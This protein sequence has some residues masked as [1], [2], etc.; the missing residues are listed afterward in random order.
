MG[1]RP[2]FSIARID[3]LVIR[4]ANVPALIDFYVGVLGCTLERT[5]EKAG[6]FQLRAGECLVDLVDTGAELGLAGGAPPGAEGRNLDHLCLRVD[7]FDADAIVSHLAVAGVEGGAPARRYG[8]EG[9]G[10]SIY[11]RDPDGNV[12]ELRGPAEPG[13]RLTGSPAQAPADR[14]RAPG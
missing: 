12:V 5:L 7:P 10:P 14:A 6:L 9:F 3:H 1:E 11:T 8:A 13:S 4:T 2:P